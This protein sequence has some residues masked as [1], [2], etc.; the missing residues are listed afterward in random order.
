MEE[1]ILPDVNFADFVEGVQCHK[2]RHHTSLKM[3]FALGLKF[4]LF[5]R[6]LVVFQG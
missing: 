3:S 6:L 5:S 4:T 1:R 2:L